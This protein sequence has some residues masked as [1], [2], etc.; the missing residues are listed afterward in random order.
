MTQAV[1]QCPATGHH[2]K[3]STAMPVQSLP[4]PRLSDIHSTDA[5]QRRLHLQGVLERDNIRFHPSIQEGVLFKT[6]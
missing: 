2:L 3:M 4:Q 5:G 6:Y 1:W